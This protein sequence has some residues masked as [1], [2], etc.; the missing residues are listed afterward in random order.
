[1]SL[2]GLDFRGLDLIEQ[3]EIFFFC[4]TPG[5]YC[6]V[7]EGEY[8]ALFRGGN[9]GG[10]NGAGNVDAVFGEGGEWVIPVVAEDV[11][12]FGEIEGFRDT[13]C[14]HCFCL[15]LEAYYSFKDFAGKTC[16]GS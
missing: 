6:A 2:V 11:P 9:Y 7:H 5:D 10:V 1:M 15:G 14:S 13:V 3:S 16:F 12:K 8:T 4:K